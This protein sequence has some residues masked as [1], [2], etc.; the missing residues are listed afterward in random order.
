[1][2]TRWYTQN[3]ILL[4]WLL[5][6]L[7]FFCN[8]KYWWQW[9][10]S[11]WCWWCCLA[12]FSSCFLAI[13]KWTSFISISLSCCF[14]PFFLLLLIFNLLCQILIILFS[15]GLLY[16]QHF[17]ILFFCYCCNISSS[18]CDPPPSSS[19]SITRPLTAPW[20]LPNHRPW[21]NSCSYSCNRISISNL[22]SSPCNI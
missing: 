22:Q 8:I 5:Q 1:M 4:T 12:K 3:T 10:W 14:F 21:W 16:F 20:C 2:N 11:N 17:F 15:I 18:C 7:V 13:F 6:A 9:G 19:S